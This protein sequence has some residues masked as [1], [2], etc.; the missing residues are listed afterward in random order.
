MYD[1][2]NLYDGSGSKLLDTRSVSLR[3]TSGTQN[4]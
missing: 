2:L 1:T 4:F 3:P